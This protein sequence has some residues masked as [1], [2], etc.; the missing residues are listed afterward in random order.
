LSSAVPNVL[1]WIVFV[2]MNGDIEFAGLTR[3]AVAGFVTTGARLAISLWLVLGAKGIGA[4]V[5]K[6]RTGGI[7][8]S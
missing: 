5:W 1:Y 4:L 6:I 2:R 3:E 7:A 8:K